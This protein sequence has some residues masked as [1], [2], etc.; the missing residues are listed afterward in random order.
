MNLKFQIK[1]MHKF[2]QIDLALHEKV[3][4]KDTILL[5]FIPYAVTDT[6]IIWLNSS[7]WKIKPSVYL[8]ILLIKFILNTVISL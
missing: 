3:D 6:M 1:Q 5:S 7:T 2:R 4:T 8:S